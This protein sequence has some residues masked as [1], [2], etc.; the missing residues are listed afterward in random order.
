MNA[1]ATA[2]SCVT[3]C[4]DGFV[5]FYNGA[6]LNSQ[7]AILASKNAAAI[8]LA[9]VFCHISSARKRKGGFH[10]SQIY[11]AALLS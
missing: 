11:S 4:I 2:R 5:P 3:A 7:T 8:A 10:H 1:A 6:V 9:F